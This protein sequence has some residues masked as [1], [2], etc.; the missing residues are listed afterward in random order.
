M[1][2][3]LLKKEA[4]ATS[5]RMQDRLELAIND[6]RDLTDRG[7]GLP[8]RG[9]G[10]ARSSACEHQARRNAYVVD[11][12]DRPRSGCGS[13]VGSVGCSR[14]GEAALDNGGFK[15]LAEFAQAV[16]FANPAAGSAFRMDDRLQNLAAPTNVHQESGDTPGA[17]LVPPE[18]RQADYRSRLRG[19]ERYHPRPHR[20]VADRVEPRRRARR[21]DDSVGHLGRPGLLARRSRADDAVEGRAHAARNEDERALRLRPRDRG[22]PRGCSAHRRPPHEQGLRGDPLEARRGLHQRRRHREAARL[23][24]VGGARHRRRGRRQTADT[25]VRQNVGKMFARVINPSKAV[26]LANQDTL[27]TLMDLKTD[28]GQ[29]IWFPNFQVAPGGT[30]LGR[31][32]YFHEHARRS[33]TRATSSSSIRWVTRPSASRT[34]SS[35]RTRSTFTSTTI[36]GRSGGSS[37]PAVSRCSPRRSAGQG[38]EHEEPLRRPRR[39]L[40]GAS[41]AIHERSRASSRL[42]H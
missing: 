13:G 33:A 3:A 29:P 10:G 19:G 5:K 31:P 20:S 36:S 2:L 37:A 38:L 30:L 39:P 16:R 7:G 21:R 40:I 28:L 1:N 6:N 42:L 11:R 17:Y 23:Y 4:R 34:A 32:V 14:P 8:G 35:S 18:Y 22:A 26:W 15:H 24:E 12:R 25:I 27:P 41:F 9:P